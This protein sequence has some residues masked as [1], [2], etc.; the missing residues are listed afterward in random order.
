VAVFIQDAC[1][2]HQYIRSR[3][4]SA[5]VERPERLRAVKIGLAAAIAHL[6][7]ADHPEVKLEPETTGKE[8]HEEPDDLAAAMGRMKLVQDSSLLQP[9]QPVS[10][11]QS[12]ASVDILSHPAVK[13]IHGDIDGDTYLENLMRWAKESW[14]KVHQ[15][16]SEIPEG[17]PQ[18]DLYRTCFLWSIYA[19]LNSKLFY[20]AVCPDS[21]NAIQGAIGTVC[22][23]VDKVISSVRNEAQ[24]TAPTELP[25]SRAFVAIRPPGHHCGEDTPSGFCFV[26]NVAIGAAHGMISFVGIW[27]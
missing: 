9:R 8:Q 26:N 10:I 20:G 23:A 14:D 7:S 5:I 27:Y 21:I 12:H 16:G 11:V 22:E 4:L 2:Q 6:E 18:G 19:A 3:D 15:G 13:F 1:L 17:L 25:F 24:T